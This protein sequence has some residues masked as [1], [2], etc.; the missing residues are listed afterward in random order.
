MSGPSIQELLGLPSDVTHPNAYQLF[1]LELGESDQATIE[2]AIN[3]RIA[4]L[5][6]AKT[7]V[8]QETW[9]RAAAAV[10]AAQ[11]TLKDPQAKA[12]LDASFG[13]IH[14]PDGL[15]TP[16]N[17]P[18]MADP[19]AS[20]LPPSANVSRSASVVAAQNEPAAVMPALPPTPGP[21]PAPPGPDFGVSAL[22]PGMEA[23]TATYPPNAS[24][25]PNEHTQHPATPIVRRRTPVRRR[26]SWGGLIF[27]TLVLGLLATIVG[28]MGYFYLKGPGNVAIV[29]TDDGYIINTGGTRDTTP[30]ASPPQEPNSSP[31]AS[32]SDGVMMTPPPVRGNPADS[33]SNDMRSDDP[34][35]STDSMGMTTGN[36]TM[37][38]PMTPANQ[39]PPANVPSDPPVTPEPTPAPAPSPT[40]TPPPAT[41]N[42]PSP[43]EISMGQ[44]AIDKALEAIRSADWE[45]MKP[46]AEASE[47][48]AVTPEQ[49]QLAETLYQ[50]ADLAT[51]YQGAVQRAVSAL[52]FGEEIQVTKTMKAMVHQVNENQLTINRGKDASGKP[53]LNTFPINQIP[54]IIAHALAPNQLDIDSPEGQA[55]MATYQA[56]GPFATAGRRNESIEILRGLE[57][58]D[59]ADPQRLADFLA[60]LGG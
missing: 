8:G 27:G 39:T 13:I 53:Q 24:G 49:K 12:E 47:S 20:L 14:E 44:V 15:E 26:R 28:G 32:Q 34:G 58:V 21:N 50:F 1:G 38:E 57:K 41:M 2:D 45:S 16:T 56:I 37:P 5:K 46:L 19:L 40:P 7:T 60:T 35:M 23:A 55:A 33:L 25:T 29:K 42:A 31:P 48:A 6:Q 22:D 59:G 17:P 4:S 9:K 54:L 43:E 30:V 51:F 36:P 52:T 10:V 3:R 18:P 11:Q